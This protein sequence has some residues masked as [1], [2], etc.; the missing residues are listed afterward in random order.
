LISSR[1]KGWVGHVVCTGRRYMHTGF[2]WGKIKETDFF[3][4]PG[5]SQKIIKCILEI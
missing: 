4:N 2:W 1:R 5:L 3:E